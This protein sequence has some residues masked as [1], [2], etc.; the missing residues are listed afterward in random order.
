MDTVPN[1]DATTGEYFKLIPSNLT[2][3]K[4][5][6]THR[7]LSQLDIVSDV[8]ITSDNK[9]IQNSI[10][11]LPAPEEKLEIKRKDLIAL[12][13]TIDQ[14]T[15]NLDFL[16]RKRDELKEYRQEVDKKRDENNEQLQREVT[17]W[18]TQIRKK[19]AALLAHLIQTGLLPEKDA[20]EAR[21]ELRIRVEDFRS[22]GYRPKLPEFR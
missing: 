22:S 2:N 11:K 8:L 20:A 14:K 19:H 4:H 13:T 15:V 21:L 12:Q 9:K 5:H 10:A 7:A 16:E 3:T 18:M 6:M 1:L 17:G